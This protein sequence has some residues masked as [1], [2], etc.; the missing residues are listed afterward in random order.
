MGGASAAMLVVVW[1]VSAASRICSV[2][3]A[4][5]PQLPPRTGRAHGDGECILCSCERPQKWRFGAYQ[6]PTRTCTMS[7]TNANVSFS[8]NSRI[9]QKNRFC[10][11]SLIFAGSAHGKRLYYTVAPLSPPALSPCAPPFPPCALSPCRT[12]APSPVPPSSV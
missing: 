7:W 9:G 8:Y 5:L 10:H 2:R 1:Q 6:F 11:F 3:P 4:S 12:S